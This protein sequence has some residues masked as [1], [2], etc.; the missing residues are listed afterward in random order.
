MPTDAARITIRGATM[1]TRTRVLFAVGVACVLAVLTG[2]LLLSGNVG[3]AIWMEGPYFPL[4]LLLPGSADTLATM[5]VVVAVYYFVCSL[6]VLKSSSRRVA[7]LVVLVV[8]AVNSLGASVWRRSSDPS[9]SA[10]GQS[11]RVEEAP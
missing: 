1:K 5:L 3:A 8:L 4:T 2:L 7:V 11:T 10:I 9:A 6:V